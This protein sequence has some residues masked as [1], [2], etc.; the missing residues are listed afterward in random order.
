[1]DLVWDGFREAFRLIWRRDPEVMGILLLTLRVSGTA[2]LLS[3][4]IGVPSGTLLGIW[5]FPG[6]AFLISLVNTGMGT[7]PVVVGLLV[8]IMLWRSGPLGELGILYTPWAMMAAQVIIALPIVTGVSMAAVAG[9]D[10]AFRLQLIGLGASR[11]Q[12]V[13]VLF[14]EARLPLLTA[15]MAGFGGVISEVGAVMMVGGNIKGETRVLTT[16]TV[17]ESN[18]G[19]FGMAIALSVILLLLVYAVTLSLTVLQQRGRVR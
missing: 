18:R 2:T 13:W 19:E 14:Q 6:R 7:P 9:I 5:R 12:M 17:L 11:V 16:A 4:L 10:P 15:V 1:M 3:M 8:M